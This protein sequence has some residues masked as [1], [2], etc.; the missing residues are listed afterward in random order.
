MTAEIPNNEIL[1][2]HLAAKLANERPNFKLYH[3]PGARTV[4]DGLCADAGFA[5]RKSEITGKVTER[6]KEVS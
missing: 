4:D 1:N 3:Y 5:N 2:E 6:F